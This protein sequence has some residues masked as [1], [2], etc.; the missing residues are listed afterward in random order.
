[1]PTPYDV[2]NAVKEKGNVC[3][4]AQEKV[5]KG[6]VFVA[7]TAF[8]SDFEVKATMDNSTDLQ[9]TNYT[10][11]N[12]ILDSIKKD[13]ETTKIGD[14]R[15]QAL[16]ETFAVEGIVTAGTQAGK[17]FFDTIYIQDETGGI[18]IFPINSGDIKVGQK[19]RV[20]G[21]LDQYLGDME[22]RV[23]SSEVIDTGIHP[24]SPVTV[25]TKQA[26]D[27]AANGGKLVQVQGKITKVV[28]ENNVLSYLLV[29]D[30]SGVELRVFI[31]GYI[32]SSTQLSKPLEAIAQVGKSFSAVGLVSYD[33]DGVRIRVRDRSEIKA[34]N[35]DDSNSSDAATKAAQNAIANL[36]DASV[37]SLTPDEKTAIQAAVSQIINLNASQISH[38]GSDSIDKL[39]ILLEKIAAGTVGKSI[40][41]PVTDV[42]AN[43]SDKMVEKPSFSGLLLA[44]G[45]TGSEAS[46]MTVALA[47]KQIV[48]STSVSGA[49]LAFEL[50]LSKGTDEIHDL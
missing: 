50:N 8:M 37:A 41:A 38:L 6:N 25:T 45:I 40:L 44:A 18:N 32:G 4:L 33:T 26:A 19:V 42:I 34:A 46:A 5:G 48:P 49:V 11:V 17:A 20:V 2:S 13:V 43:Q 16:G 24:I 30:N 22:L 31:D 3:V 14:V 29:K 36:P 1:V 9:Y 47:T 21:S 27:Y 10:I 7:G 23:I 35:S 15:K 12:N 28:L 39:E